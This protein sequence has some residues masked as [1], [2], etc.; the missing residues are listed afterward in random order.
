MVVDQ[1]FDN[2]GLL[3][4][5]GR[6]VGVT[7]LVRFA[8]EYWA[9]LHFGR[10]IIEQFA[11]DHDLNKAAPKA[12]RL[13]FSGK[14]PVALPWGGHTP[15][16]AYDVL[17]F[18]EKLSKSHATALDDYN[19]LSEGSHPSFLQNTY[20]IMASKKYENYSNDAFKRHAHEILERTVNIMEKS[21]H[22]L[23]ID[24]ETTLSLCGPLMAGLT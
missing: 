13:T 10:N 11:A 17:T 4:S 22:G 8:L 21:S 3:W 12:E 24:V 6:M 15:N 1:L 7:S 19:F 14:T 2:V 18:V 20:F 16:P 23:L 9:A 5:E